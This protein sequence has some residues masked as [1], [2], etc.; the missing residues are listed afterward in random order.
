MCICP[1][2]CHRCEDKCV[3]PLRY[4]ATGTHS[5]TAG[6]P[7]SNHLALTSPY[8]HANAAQYNLSSLIASCGLPCKHLTTHCQALLLALDGS[9]PTPEPLTS[10]VPGA[11]Y[12]FTWSAGH[13]ATGWYRDYWTRA[14][15]NGT[16][17]TGMPCVTV[18]EMYPGFDG[19]FNSG[20][21]GAMNLVVHRSFA[22]GEEALMERYARFKLSIINKLVQAN[23]ERC[24]VSMGHDVIFGEL[25]VYA[26]LL[27][28][29][30]RVVRLRRP[31]FEI[32]NS[33]LANPPMC[34]EYRMAGVV[35]APGKDAPT[36]FP[37]S[38]DGVVLCPGD[39]QAIG[40]APTREAWGRL[41]QFQ[42]A[43]WYVDETERQW[44]RFLRLYPAVRH[45]DVEW[46]YSGEKGGSS[47]GPSTAGTLERIASLASPPLWAVPLQLSPDTVQHSHNHSRGRAVP[48]EEMHRLSAE[49]EA[50][51][52]GRGRPRVIGPGTVN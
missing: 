4:S 39:K 42:R 7:F 11:Q 43:L 24:F 16:R 30:L 13:S 27:G 47:G 31:R 5:P 15:T 28:D 32:A 52:L 38:H 3:D 17:A 48:E 45:V 21:A 9:T 33:F 50:L 41:N 19:L 12:F 23:P 14:P 34:L 26:R 40:P 46:S 25:A 29:A 10:P 8:T 35:S 37:R 20:I 18:N 1:N 6:I 36:P 44:Q 22:F 2:I 49:L 51:T